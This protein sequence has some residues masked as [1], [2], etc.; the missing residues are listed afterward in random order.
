MIRLWEY[1]VS[2]LNLRGQP[3][4]F[5]KIYGLV[6]AIS[7]ERGIQELPVPHDM[8]KQGFRVAGIGQVAPALSSDIE[9]LAQFFIFF[10][11]DYPV[12]FGGSLAGRHHPS[13]AAADYHHSD[14]MLFLTLCCHVFSPP[15]ADV[16]RI[17]SK[18]ILHPLQ[19][20]ASSCSMYKVG[21]NAESFRIL[22]YYIKK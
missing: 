1:A 11:Q 5:K 19:L 20:L 10:Q 14:H 6:V 8:L 3:M 13:C 22:H 7:I 4:A 21:R 12:P 2:P 15:L 17:F 9:L 18:N 16:Q